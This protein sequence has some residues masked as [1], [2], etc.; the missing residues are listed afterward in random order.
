[1][2][3]H[4]DSCIASNHK[5]FSVSKAAATKTACAKTSKH[6]VQCQQLLTTCVNK[7]HEEGRVAG[8]VSS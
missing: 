6:K 1:M 8:G 7:D 3:K 2:N 5:V 4:S